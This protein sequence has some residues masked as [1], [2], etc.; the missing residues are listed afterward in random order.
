MLLPL[1]M[2]PNT[3]H[4][5][6]HAYMLTGNLLD[7][8]SYYLLMSPTH[9]IIYCSLLQASFDFPKSGEARA[10]FTNVIP[11]SEMTVQVAGSSRNFSVAY[12]QVNPSLQQMIVR[13][14]SGS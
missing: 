6:T 12:E 14:F 7:L 8:L 9:H 10:T 2:L 11:D 1:V 3:T 5:R 4:T 13:I